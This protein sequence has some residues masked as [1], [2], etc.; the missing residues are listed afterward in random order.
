MI[1]GIHLV[2]P[3]GAMTLVL[4]IATVCLALLRR[5]RRPRPGLILKLH[6][7]AGICTLCSG[8]LHATLVILH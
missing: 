8:L 3:T 7:I 4:L 5:V 1:F 6:K 2:E